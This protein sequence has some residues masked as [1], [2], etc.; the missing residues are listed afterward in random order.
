MTVADSSLLERP[1]PKARSGS[2]CGPSQQQ[3]DGLLLEDQQQNQNIGSQE[4]EK[5]QAMPSVTG[6]LL[7]QEGHHQSFEGTSGS[8]NNSPRARLKA[9]QQ[10]RR[11]QSCKVPSSRNAARPHVRRRLENEEGSAPGSGTSSSANIAPQDVP[12]GESAPTQGEDSYNPFLRK[13]PSC[14]KLLALED[15]IFV[16]DIPV[17]DSPVPL[18][19]CASARRPTKHGQDPN[20]DHSPTPPRQ[21]HSTKSRGPGSSRK[22]PTGS[23]PL[24]GGGF[25]EVRDPNECFETLDSEQYLLRNFSTTH[26]GEC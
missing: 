15:T 12:V 16:Q 13:V 18:R 8:G 9:A 21:R 26:K 19:R 2:I 6:R 11:S 25:L 3:V 17:D 22:G 7:L 10:A 20:R 24:K 5:Q 14:G 4:E 23:G 1:A